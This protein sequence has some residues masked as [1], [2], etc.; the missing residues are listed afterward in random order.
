MLMRFFHFQK[1]PVHTTEISAAFQKRSNDFLLNHLVVNMATSTAM[2]GNVGT[3]AFLILVLGAVCLVL[4]CVGCAVKLPMRYFLLSTAFYGAFLLFLL[5]SSKEADTENKV[6]KDDLDYIWLVRVVIGAFLTFFSGVSAI[7][8]LQFH[9]SAERTGREANYVH[10]PT[11]PWLP[12]R[13][14]L[15]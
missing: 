7:V 2:I 6:T 1:A 14:P 10:R 5:C 13:P 8:L 15:F 11:N 9:V 3:G 4:C 12:E